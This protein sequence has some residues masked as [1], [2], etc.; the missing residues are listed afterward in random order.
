VKRLSPAWRARLAAL[1]AGAAA[2]LAHPPF[3]ILPGLLGYGAL[4]LLVDGA[5]PARPLRSAFFRGWLAGTAYF[6]I[7]TWWVA[8]AFLVDIAA[9]GWMAPFAVVFMAGGIAL[10]WGLGALL[11]RLSRVTGVWRVLVFAGAFSAAE[12]LR[13]HVLTGFPW[14]LPGETWRAGS[15]MSQA[16]ALVG[17]YGLTFVTLALAATPALLLRAR[18]RAVLVAQGLAVLVLGGLLIQGSVRLAYAAAPAAD[19]PVIRIVQ[20]DVRQE[21]KYDPRLFADILGRYLTLTRQPGEEVP[22]IVIWPEGAVP[23]AANDYL[24][25]D[26]WTRAAIVSALQPGQTLLVGA[27]RYEGP[28]DRPRFYNSLIVA[29]RTAGDLAVLGTY[30]K[31]RLVPFGEYLPLDG[32]LSPLG[33]K[34]LVKIGDGF[35]TGPEPRPL[36]IAGLPVLQPLIC[37]ESLYPGFTRRGARASGRSPDLIVNVSNDAWFGAT[38]GPWQHLNLAS[39]RAIEEGTPMARA[40]PTGVSAMIDSYGRV[41]PGARLGQGKSGVIDVVLPPKVEPTPY[42]RLGD[43]AFLLFLIA[44]CAV[45]AVFHLARPF[46]TLQNAPA[47]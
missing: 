28:L 29:R 43:L 44:A 23:A 15:A 9:H 32:L 11:Y 26:T 21:A 6:A 46:K 42:R 24:A 47:G 38:S 10:F 36:A 18:G 31:H 2:A 20:P 16:A 14:N 33:I 34:N 39:Y 3:G 5:D 8:E 4:M 27:A 12:W 41:I 13:G 19:A 37:Y 25:P 22:A 30:D 1:L 45:T 7:G 35:S 40:T 17:A